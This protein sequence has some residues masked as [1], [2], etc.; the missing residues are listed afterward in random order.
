MFFNIIPKEQMFKITGGRWWN[1]SYHFIT[2]GGTSGTDTGS[3][4][5]TENNTV[6]V[7]GSHEGKSWTDSP[8][9]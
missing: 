7:T 6:G 4:H 5:T 3:D 8:P 2:P 1:T 9:P